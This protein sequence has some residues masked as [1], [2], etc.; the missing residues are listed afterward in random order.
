[1]LDINGTAAS[2]NRLPRSGGRL[3]MILD[4]GGA[5]PALEQGE[6]SGRPWERS[7]PLMFPSQFSISR[8][9]RYST[10]PNRIR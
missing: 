10:T 4:A 9:Y 2:R 3:H 5:V 6:G 1:M 8:R 7:I